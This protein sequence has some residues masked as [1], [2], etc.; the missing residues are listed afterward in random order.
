MLR[1]FLIKN[2]FLFS[3][4]LLIIGLSSCES[5]KRIEPV[6]DLPDV[7]SF[8]EHI[9]PIFEGTSTGIDITGKGRDCNGCHP[10]IY[11]PDLTAGNAYGEL[12]KGGYIDLNSAGNSKLY[13]KMSSGGSMYQY[14]NDIDVSYVL[15]W[16]NQGALDN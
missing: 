15:E 14:T 3:L 6:A 5:E 7:I 9:I 4:S 8:S 12:I 11:K 1:N 10:A 13:I 2:I 16:I